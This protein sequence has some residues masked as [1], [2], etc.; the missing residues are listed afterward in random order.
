MKSIFLKKNVMHSLRT[1]NLLTLSKMKTKSFGL[2]SFKFCTSH[3]WSQ[4]SGHIKN[5]TLV[6]AFGEKSYAQ[7]AGFRTESN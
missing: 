3:L 2:Y 6:K 7:S 4:P 5:E 1:S